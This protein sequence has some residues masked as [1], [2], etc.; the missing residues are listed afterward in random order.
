M[1]TLTDR[2]FKEHEKESLFQWRNRLFLGGKEE[3][4]KKL[5]IKV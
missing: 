5:N 2:Q 3:S 1:G 4:S